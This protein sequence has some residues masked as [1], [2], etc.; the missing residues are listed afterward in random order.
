M[1][2]WMRGAWSVFKRE[3]FDYFAT[4]VAYVFLVAYLVLSGIF[5]WYLGNLY[6]PLRV[7]RHATHRGDVWPIALLRPSHGP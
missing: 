4:P 1:K 7:R 2:N 6:D 5:T 3:F